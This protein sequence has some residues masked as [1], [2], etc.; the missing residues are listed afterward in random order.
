MYKAQ[1]ALASD[2][3]KHIVH[4]CTWTFFLTHDLAII[5]LIVKIHAMKYE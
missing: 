5:F 4:I 3:N 1:S 2:Q